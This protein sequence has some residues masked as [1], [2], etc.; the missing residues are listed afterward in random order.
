MMF[1]L[2]QVVVGE[3]LLKALIEN[4]E[5]RNCEPIKCNE[6]SNI[7]DDQYCCTK[8]WDFFHDDGGISI[9][10]VISRLYGMKYNGDVFTEFDKFKDIFEDSGYRETITIDGSEY[11]DLIQQGDIIGFNPEYDN[12]TD[13]MLV[14]VGAVIGSFIDIG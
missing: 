13:I 12:V 11:R 14:D 4:D 7:E 6:C 3:R 1:W 9:R 8:C 2:N 5:F 10:H